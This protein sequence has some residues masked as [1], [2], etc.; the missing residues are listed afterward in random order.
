MLPTKWCSAPP[1][2]HCEVA[3]T[4]WLTPSHMDGKLK[5]FDSRLVCGADVVTETGPNSTEGYTIP[6][7]AIQIAING[8]SGRFGSVVLDRYIPHLS[9]LTACGAPP[10]EDVTD[11]RG[12]F[13][14]VT[15]FT[16]GPY[17]EPF[18]RYLFMFGRRALQAINEYSTGRELLE[19][20]VQKLPQTNSHFLKA[21]DATNHFEQS[22][23]AACQAAKYAMEMASLANAP[24]I[25][26]QLEGRLRHIWNRSK[27]F[28][29]DFIQ[30]N[31]PHRRHPNITAPVWLTTDGVC[32]ADASVTFHELHTFLS[33][34]LNM[35]KAV[36]VVGTT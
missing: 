35:F 32:C 19:A 9:K 11:L 29:E 16:R 28:D 10:M 15:T 30:T 18:D 17:A 36:S 31:H 5:R 3:D 13:V 7:G 2:T 23:A 1:T 21:I 8:N 22:I 20:Y 26:D 12:A 25:K 34:L 27:H 14:L 33:T 6:A 24:I 4:T